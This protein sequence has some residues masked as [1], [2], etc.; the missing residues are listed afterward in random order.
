VGGTWKFAT[1][2]PASSFFDMKTSAVQFGWTAGL[3][4]AFA[5]RDNLSVRLDVDLGQRTIGAASGSVPSPSVHYEASVT[6]KIAFDAIRI[7][8]TLRIP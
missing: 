1:Q 4:A 2:V 8:L 7:G 6:E 5:I 3:G